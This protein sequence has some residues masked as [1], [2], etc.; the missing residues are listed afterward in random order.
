MRYEKYSTRHILNVHNHVDGGWF[1]NKYSAS[2]YVGCEWGCEYCYLRDEKYN[3]Y[4]ATKD[5][6]VMEFD[7]PFSE[8]IKVKK[9]APELLKGALSDK[10]RDLIYLDGYQPIDRKYMYA[11]DMLKVCNELD[12]PIFINEKSPMLL[13]DTDIL[14]EINEEN[15]LNIGWSIITA[16]D[17]TTRLIFESNAPPIESRFE[18]MK[19]LADNGIL[20]GTVMMPI[21]PYIYDTESNIKETVRETKKHGGKY[22]L[23]GGLTLNGYCKNHFYKALQQHSL[24]LVERYEELYTEGEN[25]AKQVAKTHRTVAKYCKKYSLQ[26][27]ITRPIDHY[28]T[29]LQ[30]NKKIAADFYLKAREINLT[31]GKSYREWAYRKAAWIIDDL[32]QSIKGIYQEKGVEGITR[33]KG[34]GRSLSRQIIEHLEK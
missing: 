3:P 1:W 15:H 11:R 31:N 20:T 2:P 28:A 30:I 25:L 29:K 4:R 34:I 32:K 6:K 10:L 17:D 27:H 12:F 7:D 9:D 23:D 13:R 8:Y 22:V 18:A 26:N 33:I 16:R 24:D 19:T 21:L 14:K 5:S